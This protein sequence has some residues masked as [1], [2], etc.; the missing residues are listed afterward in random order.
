VCLSVCNE[1]VC[2]SVCVCVCV[3]VCAAVVTHVC[4]FGFGSGFG[5]INRFMAC[6]DKTSYDCLTIKIRHVQL[7]FKNKCTIL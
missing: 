2:V 6:I 4:S 3:C 1:H 5:N 7:N